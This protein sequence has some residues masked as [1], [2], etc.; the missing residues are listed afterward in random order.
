MA[1]A[2]TGTAIKRENPISRALST[3]P[4]A[5]RGVG[6]AMERKGRLRRLVADVPAHPVDAGSDVTGGLAH[7]QAGELDDLAFV[8]VTTVPIRR[9]GIPFVALSPWRGIGRTSTL[10]SLITCTNQRPIFADAAT[11]AEQAGDFART[12][13]VVLAVD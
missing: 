11:A 9:K 13:E 7:L 12:V 6:P 10:A 8:A 4:G 3:I 1:R 2:G 5:P